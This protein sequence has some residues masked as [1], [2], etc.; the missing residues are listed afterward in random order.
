MVD[1]AQGKWMKEQDGRY[2]VNNFQRKNGLSWH[3]GCHENKGQSVLCW[4]FTLA[5]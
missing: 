5:K 4:S 3:A 1:T 2:S